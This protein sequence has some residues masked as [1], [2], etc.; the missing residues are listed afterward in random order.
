M[1]VLKGEACIKSG[2][3]D[4]ALMTLDEAVRVNKTNVRAITLRGI[5]YSK[6]GEYEKAMTDFNRALDIMPECAEAYY[7]RGVM[8]L[9][10]AGL[11]QYQ[12]LEVDFD[13]VFTQAMAD[14]D[15]AV[16]YDP[17]LTIAYLERSKAYVRR[18]EIEGFVKGAVSYRLDPSMTFI[19][20]Y[21]NWMNSRNDLLSSLKADEIVN[22]II[23]DT[24]ALIETEVDELKQK[25]LSLRVNPELGQ[26]FYNRALAFFLLQH[27]SQ[28]VEDAEKALDLEYPV[29]PEI[30]R[31]CREYL[32]LGIEPRERPL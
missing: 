31:A 18:Y 30:I 10:K 24:T 8:E 12:G 23:T 25:L 6:I 27:Y 22:T 29:D 28:A 1:M 16:K 4:D 2:Q 17:K 7:N 3:Y 9:Y 5:V 19:K 32:A 21:E 14:F 11:D 15:R 26:A 20:E 13:A